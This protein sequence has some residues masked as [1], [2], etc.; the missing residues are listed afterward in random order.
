M[1]ARGRRTARAAAGGARARDPHP[2]EE[3]SALEARLAGGLP[4]L[5]VVRGE[6]R[7]YRDRALARLLEAAR[8]RG[9]ELCRHDPLDPD[10][11]LAALLDDLC[12]GALFAQTRCVVLL[13]ADTL[14]KKGAR[15]Y[16]PGFS[17]ALERRLAAGTPG[18]VVIAADELRADHA[19]LALSERSG[20]FALKCRR[21]WDSPPP[22]DP[23]PRRTE[24]VRWVQ[25]RA[26]ELGLALAPEQALFVAAATGNDLSALADRLQ[27]LRGADPARLRALVAWEAGGSPWELAERLV[28]GDTARSVLGIEALFRSG[29]QGRDGARTVDAGALVALLGSALAARL[30]EAAAGAEAL[31][32]GATVQQA[33]AWAGVKGGPRAVAAFQA[34]LGRRS[35]A[36]WRALAEQAA[37]LERRARSGAVVDAA[38]FA[39]LALAWSRKG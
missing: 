11:Q 36:R 35:P 3:L 38:D 21:L 25:D 15:K 16:S 1:A 14:V 9:D 4:P 24:L 12:G 31:A 8:A 29:F 23:D 28:D 30:R 37:A 17:D 7:W 32:G 19:L 33:A 10:F 5:V 27:G 39:A 2:D 6:E 26:R 13:N 18:T 22:W 20:G 34:R